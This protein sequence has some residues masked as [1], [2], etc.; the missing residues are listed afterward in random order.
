MVDYVTVTLL[1]VA[2]TD[3]LRAIVLPCF[4]RRRILI[5]TILA[6]T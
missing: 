4:L 5:L 3:A 2:T 6:K 1:A